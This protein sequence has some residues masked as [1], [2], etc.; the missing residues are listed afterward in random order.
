MWISP[1]EFN[2]GKLSRLSRW[3]GVTKSLMDDWLSQAA[4][5]RKVHCTHGVNMSNARRHPAHT[6]TLHIKMA[7]VN[8]RQIFNEFQGSPRR[9]WLARGIPQSDCETVG[10]HSH[11]VSLYCIKFAPEARSLFSQRC[12]LINFVSLSDSRQSQ[13]P[14]R[15][16][17]L[18]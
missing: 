2:A 11:A 7:S 6:S 1:L 9:G 12:Q 17:L 8:L 15:T 14:P 3:C 10:E 4:L 13:L 5:V 18:K 16:T